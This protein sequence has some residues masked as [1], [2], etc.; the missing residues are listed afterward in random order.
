MATNRNYDAELAALID[1]AKAHGALVDQALVI[2]PA[3]EVPD[4]PRFTWV[5]S[6]AE[7]GEHAD[8]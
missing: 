5:E 3:P 1:D 7:G 4:T 6:T 2:E 8:A